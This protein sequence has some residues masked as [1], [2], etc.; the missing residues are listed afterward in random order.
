MNFDVG[1]GKVTNNTTEYEGLL[2]G[3]RAATGLGIKHLVVRGNSQ[4]VI[5]QVTKEYGS[6]QM[7]A[8][9]DKV[10]KLEQH[11]DGIEMESIPR[12][13]NFIADKLSKIATRRGPISH[14]V[15]VERLT[16]SLVEIASAPWG[17]L[18]PTPRALGTPAVPDP[19]VPREEIPG[20]LR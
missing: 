4:L 5:R 7:G 12:G 15:F 1:S 8:Y 14:G 20:G 19:S 18:T 6:P 9:V 3:L 17:P 10:R 16:R 2:V 11:F 13:E